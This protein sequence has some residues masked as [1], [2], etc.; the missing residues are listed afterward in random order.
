VLLLWACFW[1]WFGLS[2]GL[3][4]HLAPLG[5]ALHIAAPAAVFAFIAWL[6]Y[7]H[8]RQA[9]WILLGIAAIILLEYN[10]L[11]GHRGAL[12]VLEVGSIISGP[13]LVS[14]LLFLLHARS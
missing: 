3:A 11:M 8:P 14:G 7:R 6:S 10:H 2:S 5:I 4:Q 12:Y 13:P 9:G 1:L